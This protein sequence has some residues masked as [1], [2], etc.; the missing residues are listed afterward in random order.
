[1]L[2][3]II[4]FWATVLLPSIIGMPLNAALQS[5]AEQGNDAEVLRLLAEGAKM[6]SKNARGFT[7]LMT[8]ARAGNLE[9]VNLL[10]EKG[11]MFK[12]ETPN[13]YSAL[14]AATAGGH[15]S[16]VQ[17]LLER[18]ANINAGEDLA[19]VFIAAHF[20][21]VEVMRVLLRNRVSLDV[22]NVRQETPF[23]VAV[24]SQQA[25]I[26][27][28]VAMIALLSPHLRTLDMRDNAGNT[29]LINAIR[30][31]EDGDEEIVQALVNHGADVNGRGRDQK[32]PLMCAAEW[33]N[34]EIIQKLLD[35][36]ARLDLTDAR[37]DTAMILATKRGNIQAV[38]SLARNGADVEG[39]SGGPL[40][41]P[42]LIASIE[43]NTDL[44]LALLEL[45]ANVDMALPPLR[46][47]ALMYAAL[48]G[49][50]DVV[51]VLLDHGADA[52]LSTSQ[53]DTALSMARS[54]VL[55]R[56]LRQAMDAPAAAARR[57]R[58]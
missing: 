23:M 58:L 20:G 13:Q 54:P 45:G 41:T 7:P 32:T 51:H 46:V 55:Q 24:G 47:T 44:V 50:T 28:K 36:G 43:G 15:P 14:M 53:G 10:L 21:H 16:T 42:L 25:S 17:L 22:Y 40:F 26:P 29:V 35:L 33:G 37:Q 31:N 57:L 49:Y 52:R 5:A 11:A 30:N 48:H 1:M 4:V 56:L 18:G 34:S 27:Q 2:R 3:T 39:L 38:V 8:A 6:D 9:T 12:P 19:P